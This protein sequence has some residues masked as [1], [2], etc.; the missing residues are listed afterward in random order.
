MQHFIEFAYIEKSTEPFVETIVNKLL[1]ELD[2]NH[3]EM[4][5]GVICV[6]S[7][8]LSNTTL[9]SRPTIIACL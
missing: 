4:E 8:C 7:N 9:W 3:W 2:G 1:D 6:L 5:I